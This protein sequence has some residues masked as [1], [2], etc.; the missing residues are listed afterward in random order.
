MRPGQSIKLGMT[1]SAIPRDIEP[2][3]AAGT[4]AA[5]ST[6]SSVA[7]VKKWMNFWAEWRIFTIE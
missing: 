7:P 3:V 6:G 5:T 2:V 1:V 4:G